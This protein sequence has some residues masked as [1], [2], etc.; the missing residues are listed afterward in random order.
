MLSHVYL[1]PK[2]LCQGS[3]LQT[4]PLE[5]PKTPPDTGTAVLNPFRYLGYTTRVES[6]MRQRSGGEEEIRN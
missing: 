5:P 6:N 1:A 4:H 2:L 3:F